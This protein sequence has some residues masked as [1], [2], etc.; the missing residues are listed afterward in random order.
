[1]GKPQEMIQEVYGQGLLNLEKYPISAFKE[2]VSETMQEILTWKQAWNFFWNFVP[3]LFKKK[4]C[5]RLILERWVTYTSTH[6]NITIKSLVKGLSIL[7]AIPNRSIDIS[8][9]PVKK[10]QKVC[11]WM[12]IN[13]VP[14]YWMCA[15]KSASSKRVQVCI[16][17]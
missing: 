7:G 5:F 6:L 12:L 10:N 11:E 3:T 1:M 14:N 4:P 9:I 16:F 15:E 8:R 17:I 2:K 13:G